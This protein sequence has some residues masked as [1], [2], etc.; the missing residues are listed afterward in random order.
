MNGDRWERVAALSG[1]LVAVLFLVIIAL[2][3]ELPKASA[4]GEEVAG[5]FRR[6][7]TALVGL[8]RPDAHERPPLR[9]PVQNGRTLRLR[10]A[11]PNLSHP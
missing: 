3:G 1:V 5:Y 10:N 6:H 7:D 8:G 2:A 11:G 9:T 4:P